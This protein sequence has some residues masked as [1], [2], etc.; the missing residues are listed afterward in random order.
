MSQIYTVQ[1]VNVYTQSARCTDE[2]SFTIYIAVLC[3]LVVSR[4]VDFGV[5]RYFLACSANLIVLQCK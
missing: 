4:Y 2:R 3:K 1:R 5:C